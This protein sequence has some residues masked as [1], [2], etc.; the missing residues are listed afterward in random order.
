MHIPRRIR[1]QV[2]RERSGMRCRGLEWEATRGAGGSREVGDEAGVCD[3]AAG[4]V[5]SPSGCDVG[6]GCGGGVEGGV[7][8]AAAAAA[9]E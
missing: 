9:P 7:A 5:E 8:A 2:W 6:V 3:A 1:E 4:G